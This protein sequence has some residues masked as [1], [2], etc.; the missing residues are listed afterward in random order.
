MFIHL[1]LSYRTAPGILPDPFFR[2]YVDCIY[3]AKHASDSMT[4][5]DQ[6]RL[7]PQPSQ[8]IFAKYDRGH[9]GG[10]DVGDL[11]IFWKEQRM[12]FGFVRWTACALE[13]GSP[14]EFTGQDGHYS[15]LGPR[16]ANH[17]TSN[18]SRDVTESHGQQNHNIDPV[19][20]TSQRRYVKRDKELLHRFGCLVHKGIQ[21]FEEGIVKEPAAHPPDFGDDPI[22]SS[23]WILGDDDDDIPDVWDDVFQHLPLRQ[24]RQEDC[25]LV[26]LKQDRDFTNLWHSENKATKSEYRAYYLPFHGTILITTAYGPTY[27]VKKRGV[28]DNEIQQ[29]IPKLHRL[30]D[31]VWEVWKAVTDQLQTLRFLARDGIRNRI[32]IPLLDYLFKRDRSSLEVPWD[33]RLTFGLDSDEGKAL[34][35]TPHGIAVAWLLIHHHEKLGSRDPRVSI[36]QV[37]GH[38]CMIWELIPEGEKSTFDDYKAGGR[39]LTVIGIRPTIFRYRLIGDL[40]K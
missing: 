1:G 38:R 3:K 30:S 32:T 15:N 13:W 18:I 20:Q 21:Y 22:S 27:W 35:A 39:A 9:L 19:A 33:R 11:W 28:P 16:I 2:I 8:D 25:N 24:P 31:A 40:A 10:L 34:L 26:T 6:G 17:D 14:P 29:H 7:R 5:D 12:V 36:F 23:G 4:Y 37:E